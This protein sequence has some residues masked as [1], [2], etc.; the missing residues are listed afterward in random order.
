MTPA[1]TSVDRQTDHRPVL[2]NEP[3]S[4]VN[5]CESSCLTHRL[6]CPMH[7]VPARGPTCC[8]TL[9]VLW[10]TSLP[11]SIS[12][13]RSTMTSLLKQRCSQPTLRTP[14]ASPLMSGSRPTQGRCCEQHTAVSMHEASVWGRCPTKPRPSAFPLR[15]RLHS[16]DSGRT[17]VENCQEQSVQQCVSLTY[18]TTN[19]K[20]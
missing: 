4:F 19:A 18:P 1:S 8:V 13:N 15:D 2:S 16:V 7:R 12:P 11:C 17:R 3:Q 14:T 5:T 20:R 9:S 6:T 10:T